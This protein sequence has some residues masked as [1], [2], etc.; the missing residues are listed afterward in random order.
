MIHI[1]S[2]P[3]RATLARP[4]EGDHR[5]SE[6][7]EW[8]QEIIELLHERVVSASEYEGAALFTFR[9]KPEAWQSSA[10]IRDCDALITGDTSHS[11]GPIA[12]EVVVEAV[13]HVTSGQIELSAVIVGGGV[14]PALL[15]LRFFGNLKPD[16]V[17]GSVVLDPRCNG[18]KLLQARGRGPIEQRPVERVVHAHIGQYLHECH[19][20][21]PFDRVESRKRQD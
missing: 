20:L 19:S 12:G 17:P 3:Q 5:N 2:L 6:F 4:V 16:R 8:E 14:Q 10:G 21:S 9:L 15:G 1:D 11:E 7:G 13:A 18:A